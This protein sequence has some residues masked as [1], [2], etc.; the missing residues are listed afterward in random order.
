MPQKNTFYMFSLFAK[1]AKSNQK[2]Y[3]SVADFR[4]MRNAGKEQSN[5]RFLETFAHTYDA[6]LS[7]PLDFNLT[8]NQSYSFE[9]FIKGAR[10]VAL[11]DSGSEW[12]HFNLT[13]PES[14]LWTLDQSI[15]ALGELKLYAKPI[16][17][18]DGKFNG[19]ALYNVV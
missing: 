18:Q 17:L 6:Y 16:D 13:N 15:S 12:Y 4:V 3:S 10:D 9:C 7:S 2:T 5:T 11:V 14:M 8:A 1:E 19:I